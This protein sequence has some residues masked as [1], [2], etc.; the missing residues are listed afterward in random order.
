[1][2]LLGPDAEENQS[3]QICKKITPMFF[4]AFTFGAIIEL[5]QSVYNSNADIFD[6]AADV[7]GVALRIFCGVI[8]ASFRKQ[9]DKK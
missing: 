7:L 6:W 3:T 8:Y 1:M 9:Q 2:I 5:V 4:G